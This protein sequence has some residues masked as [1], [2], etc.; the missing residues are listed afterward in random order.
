MIGQNGRD[1]DQIAHNSRCY[2]KI[3]KVV[4]GLGL[5]PSLSHSSTLGFVQQ[6]FS[7]VSFE[8]GQWDRTVQL[9][10]YIY[11]AKGDGATLDV[12]RIGSGNFVPFKATKGL[13]VTVCGSTAAFDEGFEAGTPMPATGTP[14]RP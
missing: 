10:C 12:L 7:Y 8:R 4:I 13:K 3:A 1:R 14:K 11:S 5:L 2:L 6:K 9:P